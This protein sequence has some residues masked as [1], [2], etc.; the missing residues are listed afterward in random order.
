MRRQTAIDLAL[1]PRATELAASLRRTRTLPEG[2]KS[3]LRI[4]AEGEWRDP[5]TEHAYR[6]HSPEDIRIATASFLAALLFEQRADPYRVLGLGTEA[7]PEEVRENKRLLLKWLHPDRNP[8]PRER[9]Y[10]ACVLEAAE[11]IEMGNWRDTTP[12]RAPA[13]PPR[14]VVPIRKRSGKP[15]NVGGRELAV[16]VIR[17]VLRGAAI[18][19]AAAGAA[20][21][22]L[23][24]WRLAMHE[25]IATS[26]MRF[27]E[28]AL[29]VLRPQ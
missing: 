24:L 25:P 29:N 5:S 11:S 7:R 16:R 22:G 27:S 14:V 19:L 1:N 4:V 23:T 12:A 13:R 10:L 9:G 15:V 3:L 20:V 6:Q 21:G 17:S 18:A 26:L 8:S 28:M 2:V